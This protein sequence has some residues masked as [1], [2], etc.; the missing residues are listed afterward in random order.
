M[1]RSEG[2][3]AGD[4]G[5]INPS[6]ELL[7]CLILE[8]PSKEINEKMDRT[9]DIRAFPVCVEAVTEGEFGSAILYNQNWQN[10]D[11]SKE[12]GLT[13]SRRQSIIIGAKA[14]E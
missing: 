12:R 9:S 11:M 2:G 14:Q 13:S 10:S 5:A 6:D 3:T 7:V 4:R 8:T 1:C